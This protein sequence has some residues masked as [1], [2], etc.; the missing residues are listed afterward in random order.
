MHFLFQRIPG[1]YIH[2]PRGYHYPHR[3][4]PVDPPE[5]WVSVKFKCGHHKDV[6]ESKS[7]NVYY[8]FDC[9]GKVKRCPGRP[10]YV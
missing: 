1:E 6:R 10:R 4:T 7:P 9:P 3:G 2:G 5:R 8:C